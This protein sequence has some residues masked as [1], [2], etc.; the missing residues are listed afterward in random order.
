MSEIFDMTYRP[1]LWALHVP[2]IHRLT[3]P[4]RDRTSRSRPAPA[5][6]HRLQL[7]HQ[8]V[9]VMSATRPVRAALSSRIVFVF[10]FDMTYRRVIHQ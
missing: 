1:F 10:F 4:C 5:F 3:N 2:Q 8:R 9:P 6:A 7:W